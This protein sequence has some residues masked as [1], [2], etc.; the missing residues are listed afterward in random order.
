MRV[1]LLLALSGVLACGEPAKPEPIPIG[2]L[3]SFTG[4]QAA[5]SI[6]SER[7]LLMA[8]GSANDAGGVEGRPLTLVARDTRSDPSRA[9][10]PARE[11]ID[12]NVAAVIGPDTTDLA[13]ATRTILLDRTVFL[14]SFAATNVG[15]RPH[16]WFVLGTPLGRIVCEMNAQLRADGR[17]R[18]LLIMNPMDYASL[19]GWQLTNLYGIPK[20]VL[21][22]DDE[23]TASTL[24]PIL[25]ASADSYILA[26][27][28][29][30]A[31]SLVYALSAIGALGE[32]GRWY[33]SP[34]LH[35]PAFLA[36]IPSGLLQGARGV[37]QGTAAG[38]AEFREAFHARWQDVP[39]DNAY[40]FYDA[41]AVLVLA[42]QRAM[43]REGAIPQTTGLSP[44]VLAVTQTAGTPV[45]WNELDR[46]LELLR[47]GVE[48]GYVGL[49][50]ST[51]FDVT[52]QTREA[53]A[54][55]WT[56]GP[57]GFADIPRQSDC[58]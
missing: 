43:T 6:N 53:T 7:A 31:S 8:I 58:R 26:A 44:H 49:T 37:A 22:N 35:T 51:E 55:W 20:Y 34:T 10:G 23:P 54:N 14:P 33:L 56:I 29:A 16:A 38:V 30:S 47:Q 15:A 39:L 19:I 2:L 41:G 1:L 40:P 50:G 36:T 3:L 25:S 57:N 32:A 9:S 18:P 21:A 12:A 52:G 13:I 5:D 28:P 27:S 42:L 45:R 4:Y 24:Q 11:L 46:G 48:V 17:E